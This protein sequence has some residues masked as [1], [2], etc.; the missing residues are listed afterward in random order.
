KN[1]IISKLEEISSFFNSKFE[2]K[3]IVSN[4]RNILSSDLIEQS[5]FKNRALHVSYYEDG[6][7]SGRKFIFICGLNYEN[8]PGKMNFDALI[9]DEEKEKIADDY[10]RYEILPEDRLKNFYSL[11]SRQA[12]NVYLSCVNNKVISPAMLSVYRSYTGNNISYDEFKEIIVVTGFKPVTTA[13]ELSKGVIAYKNRQSSNITEHDGVLSGFG[14]I[15]DPRINLKPVSCSHIETIARCPYQ[16]LLRFVFKFEDK[17]KR[18]FERNEWMSRLDRGNILHEIFCDFLS[19][20][21]KDKRDSNYG[22]II[23]K[24]IA[25]EAIKKFEFK[26]P[27]YPKGI[28]EKDKAFIFSCLDLFV[29]KFYD[30]DSNRVPMLFEFAFDEVKMNLGEKYI[31][32]RGKI[33]RI[34]VVGEHKY[35]VIDYKISK[36][37]KDKSSEYYKQGKRMQPILYSEA[38]R[39]LFR[40]KGIDNEAVVEKAGYYFP[41]YLGHNQE[42]LRAIKCPDNKKNELLNDLFDIIADGLFLPSNEHMNNMGLCAYCEFRDSVCSMY[43]KGAVA[44]KY[45]GGIEKITKL[46]E[47]E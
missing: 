7:Y 13:V 35:Y 22:K 29:K 47:Y 23:I 36:A 20:V 1:K 17:S 4:I 43:E 21:Y 9:L 3:D 40:Q 33:D 19:I 26:K 38:V 34:D 44:G 15:F 16:Y 12:E 5:C 8:I 39:T 10:R 32:L 42:E 45:E 6:G 46:G 14:D 41:T 18:V 2:L 11:V 24:Q 25:D 37:Y 31:N 30:L 28:K 27:Y